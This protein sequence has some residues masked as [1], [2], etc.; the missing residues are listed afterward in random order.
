MGAQINSIVMSF[1]TAI[2][3]VFSPRVHYIANNYSGKEV[4]EKFSALFIKVGRIQFMVLGL[5]ITGLIFFG[6]YFITNIFAGAEYEESY[7]VGVLLIVPALVPYIQNLGIEIQRSVNKH[8]T[9]TLVYFI[10]AIFN[11]FIS[12]PLATILGP[13]G[14]ALGTSISLI[15]GNIIFMNIY[16][17]KS[18][19]L[20][21]EKFWDNIFRIL[22]SIMSAIALGIVMQILDIFISIG[23]Y[24][25]LICVYTLTYCLFVYL[26]GM[27]QEEKKTIK[28]MLNKIKK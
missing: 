12:V 26:I 5:I 15:C 20:D 1:S 13:I 8:Q 19:G 4:C 3:S 18:I 24:L 14:S 17:K 28:N 10:M 9:R 23:L 16:Y 22:I 27:N 7:Y 6:K 21:I 2:S 25:F 11:L